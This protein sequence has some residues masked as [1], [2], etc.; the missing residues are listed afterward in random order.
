MENMPLVESI[1]SNI[2]GGGKVPPVIS[3]E[4]LV[5]WGVE[6][7]IKAYRNFKS[8]KGSQFNTYA[9]YRIRGEMLDRIRTEWQYR[10]PA[11]YSSY[12]K[13][14]QERI[15]D[16]VEEYSE[17]D[18]SVVPEREVRDLIANAGIS[19]LISMDNIDVVS[20][21]QGLMNPEDEYIEEETNKEVDSVLTEEI[22]ELEE[23][24]Q[25]IV[26]LFY[27]KGLKQKEI[28]EHMKYSKSKVCRI[29]MKVLDKLKRRLKRRAEEGALQ[30]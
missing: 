12:R 26:R 11:E 6:G 1:A 19:Y 27:V 25:R 7:L 13:K 5:S 10:N 20:D 8:N 30:L 14:L 15:A 16:F 9:Y 28:A 3:F 23:D 24:E 21:Q 29:H 17:N 4:D 2:I 22:D 18:G